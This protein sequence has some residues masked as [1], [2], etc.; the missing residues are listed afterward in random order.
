MKIIYFLIFIL[1]SFNAFAFGVSPSNFEVMLN[2][3][4]GIE[5]EFT[6]INDDYETKEFEIKSYG[7]DFINF[8]EFT[9]KI[10][11]QSQENIKFSINVPYET[12]EGIYE[13]R[14]YINKIKHEEGGVNLDALLGIKIKVNVI[15]NFTENYFAEGIN[16]ENKY[17]Q[18]RNDNFLDEF[19]E[20]PEIFVFYI[21][22]AVI[23]F[24]CIF[25]IC[26][27]ILKNN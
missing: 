13:G 2:N 22:I 4:E 20:N 7:I 6:L 27:N 18:N 9:F 16:S 24:A 8:T 26:R 19:T 11:P 14:I 12:N 23:L 15:S 3:N 1:I 10:A 25:V 21:L 17:L 5:K